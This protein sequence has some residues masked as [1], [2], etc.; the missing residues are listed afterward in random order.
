MKNFIIILASLLFVLS[1]S[2]DFIK[3]PEFSAINEKYSGVYIIKE[4]VDIGNEETMAAG[5][6]VKIY[7]QT[8]DESVKVYAYNVKE[9]REQAVG[10]NILY[11]FKTDFPD[12]KFDAEF[13]DQELQKILKEAK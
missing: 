7:I 6:R 9:D 5:S 11:L 2:R 8:T 10:K 12:K 1:C 13:F 3:E 4:K